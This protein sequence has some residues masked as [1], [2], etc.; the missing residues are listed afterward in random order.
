MLKKLTIQNYALIDQL[1]ITPGSGLN[2]MT[3][4]TGAGKSIILGALSLILGQRAESKYFYNQEKKCI[5]EGRF[6]IGPYQLDGLFE[7][8]DLDYEPESTLRREISA[9]G[10]SRAFINDTPVTLAQLKSLGEQLIDIHS[11]HATLQIGTEAFQ[12]LVLDSVAQNPALL[13]DY[14]STFTL[15]RQT[16]KKWKALVERSQQANLEVEY[17]QYL[18]DELELARLHPDEQEL[19]ESEQQKLSH[20]EEIK[21]ALLSANHLLNERD[22][23]ATSLLREALHQLR[24]VSAYLPTADGLLDRLDSSLIEIKDIA[25]EMAHMESVTLFDQRRLDEVGERL[26]TLYGL[27]QK[28]RV[29]TVEEL[30][31]IQEELGNKISAQANDQEE[32]Q[33]MEKET[34]RLEADSLRLAQK[35]S[36]SRSD[37][38]VKVETAI[39]DTLAEVG[40]PNAV[41]RIE[42]SLAEELRP[43]GQDQVRFLFSANKGQLPQPLNKVA[44]GGELSRLMLAI[45]ALIAKTSSLPTIIFDE[46]DTG[47]SG[48]VALRVGNVMEK[49]ADHMQ[50]IAITHLPQIASKGSKHYKIYKEEQDDK[51]LSRMKVLGTYERTVEIAQMLSGSNPGDAAL[52]HAKELLEN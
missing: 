28:H 4:E 22:D 2:I 38:L 31:A 49:M 45:K 17:H 29:D 37:S 1:D 32:L 27:Q 18:F 19:L 52:Q 40:I 25:E 39:R 15:Y 12:L 8:Q 30:M 16:H 5:I 43:N 34:A 24:Q 10:K 21:R 41:L 36:A 35:L 47:I 50:V 9:D 23:A 44:S 20:A 26:S 14:K 51:T 7:E 13:Q 48:E 11:Q 46:I 6:E 3:G 42:L 33:H